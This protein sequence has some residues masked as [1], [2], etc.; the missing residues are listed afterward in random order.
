MITIKLKYKSS[1]DFQ[2]FLNKL[3]QQF[4]CVYKY[5][6]NRLYDGLT[7]SDIYHQVSK[8]NNVELVK[9]RLINDCVDFASRLHE[10]DKINNHKSIFGGRKNFI[11]LIK[12]KIT[13]SEYSK[14]R[15]SSLYVQGETSRNG[16]RYFTLDIINEK[17]IFKYDR[18]NHYELNIK[19]SK[20]QSKQLIELQSLCEENKS[21]FTVTM[22]D[23]FIHISFDEIKHE[24]INLKSDRYIGIDLNPTNIGISVC[25][26]NQNIIDTYDFEFGEIINKIKNKSII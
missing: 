12:G 25:D 20:N 19:L 4:S 11:Q 2:E 26:S 24:I 15:L 13:K 10:K 18:N 7:K 17:I 22:D 8:L 14:K 3:R 1:T 16:N 23:E 9:S 6:Y 21:K 5:S